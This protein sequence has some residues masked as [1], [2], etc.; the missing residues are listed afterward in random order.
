MGGSRNV[1]ER[2]GFCYAEFKFDSLATNAGGGGVS[3][4]LLGSQTSQINTLRTFIMTESIVSSVTAVVSILHR[5]R[6]CPLKFTSGGI[7]EDHDRDRDRD[8]DRDCRLAI[9][10]RKAQEERSLCRRS[11]NHERPYERKG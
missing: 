5:L 11:G 9:Y 2:K 4:V 1:H 8:R 6:L 7:F 10:G 3:G